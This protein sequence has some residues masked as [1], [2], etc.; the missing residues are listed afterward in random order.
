MLDFGIAKMIEDDGG[1]D[2][3]VT[4]AG[5]LLGTPAYMSPEQIN[6]AFD[7]E[8]DKPPIDGRSDLYSTGVVLYHLLTGVRPFRG[9]SMGHHPCPSHYSRPLR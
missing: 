5:D 1:G 4:G 9:N 2:Q 3:T 8:E 7:K 6:A